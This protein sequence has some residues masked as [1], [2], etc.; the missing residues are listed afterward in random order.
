MQANLDGLADSCSKIQNVLDATKL[1]AAPLLT[2]TQVRLLC[3]PHHA[4]SIPGPGCVFPLSESF[5]SQLFAGFSRLQLPAEAQ[6]VMCKHV[7]NA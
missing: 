1:S 6:G 4:F 2:E 5:V 3:K 7:G